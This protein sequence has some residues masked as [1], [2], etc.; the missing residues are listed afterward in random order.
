MSVHFNHAKFDAT[1]HDRE[2]DEVMVKV[3]KMSS[4][5]FAYNSGRKVIRPFCSYAM[6]I[7]MSFKSD[8]WSMWTTVLLLD[9]K[10]LTRLNSA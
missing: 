7:T 10:M 9:L 4:Y 8:L 3:T 6:T 2:R 1:L 5:V